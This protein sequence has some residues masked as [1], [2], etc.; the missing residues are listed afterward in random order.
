MLGH[1][2]STSEGTSKVLISKVLLGVLGTACIVGVVIR[3]TG[4]AVKVDVGQVRLLSRENE[5]LPCYD[6]ATG[7]A[8]VAA[9]TCLRF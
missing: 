3:S 8:H 6:T 5:E 4:S 9:S 7:F 1:Y 2:R